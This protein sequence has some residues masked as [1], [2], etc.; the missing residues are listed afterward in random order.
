MRRVSLSEFQ[1]IVSIA[2]AAE[3]WCIPPPVP[4]PARII[5]N[6]NGGMILPTEIHGV[7]TAARATRIG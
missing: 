6:P 1:P 2:T 3:S 7:P 5:L 4:G